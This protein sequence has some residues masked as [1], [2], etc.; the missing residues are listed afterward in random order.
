MSDLRKEGAMIALDPDREGK[1]KTKEKGK[2]GT[3]KYL[4]RN[5]ERKVTE[6]GKRGRPYS[7]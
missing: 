1:R 3:T 5:G 4:M 2:C 6:K 7:R